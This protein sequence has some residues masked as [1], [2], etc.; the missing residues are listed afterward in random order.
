[1]VLDRLANKTWGIHVIVIGH[2]VGE[3]VAQ[4]IGCRYDAASSQ[5]LG[6][7][8]SE[9]NI[10]AGAIYENWNGTSIV[11]HFA[12]DKPM[13]KGYLNVIFDYPFNQLGA[14][15]IICP[16]AQDNEKSINLCTK[17]GFKEEARIKEAHPSGDM[18][19]YTIRRENCRWLKG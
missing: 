12:C 1:M 3:W 14:K 16:I 10:T 13:V 5:G 17:L 9:G 11:A 8:D 2:G 6:W 4:R 18:I 19:L 7:K 15:K